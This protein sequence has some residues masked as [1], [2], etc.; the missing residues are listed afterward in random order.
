MKPLYCLNIDPLIPLEKAWNALEAAGIDILYSSEED[1]KTELFVYIQSKEDLIPFDWIISYAPYKL[2]PTDWESQ[3]ATHGLNFHDGYVHADLS[4][5]K[6]SAPVLRLQPGPGFGDLS[7]PTTRLVLGLLAK[8]F[9]QHTVIDIGCGSGILS[10][11]A[12]AMGAPIAYGI[13]IDLQAL[14]HARQNAYLNNL[15]DRCH[16]CIPEDFNW[17]LTP[18][19]IIIVMNMIQ[20]EQQIAWS[21]L[22]KL[23]AQQGW[24]L[25]SGIRLEERE[26]YLV[27]TVNWGWILQEEC[28]EEGWLAFCFTAH[29]NNPSC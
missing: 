11:A 7:H 3:W 15:E 16:F 12:A 29:S 20:T 8:H 18:K 13:D 26:M 2:P 6:P 27:K 10:L 19:P 22:S 23:H 28:E 14:E 25:T 24:R 5:L 4:S 1:G 17:A 9:E 21:S